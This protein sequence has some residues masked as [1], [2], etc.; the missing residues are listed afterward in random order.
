[1][2][3]QELSKSLP[4]ATITTLPNPAPTLR[5]PAL[6]GRPHVAYAGRFS[7]EKDLHSLLRAWERLV[8]RR[9]GGRLTLIGSGGSFRSVEHELRA[10]VESSP[11]LRSSVVFTGWLAETADAVAQSD[12]FAFPSLSEGMSNALIE[13]CALG[14]VVV[15]SDIPPNLAVVGAD[16]PL[17]YAAGD[18]LALE[19]AL[20]DALG[21][22]DVRARSVAHIAERIRLLSP[23]RIVAQLEALLL[24][25]DRARNQ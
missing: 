22:E 20:E 2:A 8:Q 16:Y 1:M 6:T 4:G 25:A 10:E 21:N 7:E 17:L 11:L 18:A 9:A 24:D 14:R 15:A 3:A 5:A 12:V 13:A 23:D 19:R